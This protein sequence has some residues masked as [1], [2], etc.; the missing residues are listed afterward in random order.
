MCT[1]LWYMSFAENGVVTEVSL[2]QLTYQAWATC[3]EQF[4]VG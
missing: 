3:A 4:S 2:E 1:R